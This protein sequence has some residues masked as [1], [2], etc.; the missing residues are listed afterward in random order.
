MH[1]TNYDSGM[2]INPRCPR[3]FGKKEV[4]IEFSAKKNQ[5]ALTYTHVHTHYS[6]IAYTTFTLKTK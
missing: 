4:H 1:I 2:V 6:L 3:T 5:V